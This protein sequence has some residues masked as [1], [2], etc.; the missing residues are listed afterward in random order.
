[1]PEL[2]WAFDL[3][4]SQNLVDQY[5]GP[6]AIEPERFNAMVAR[7]QGTDLV[8][9]VEANKESF[10]ALGED[11]EARSDERRRFDLQGNVAVIPIRGPIQKFASSMS[12][13]TSS[14]GARRALRAAVR[15]PDVASI[16]LVVDSPGGT[17]AGTM[18]LAVEVSKAREKKPVYA[19]L[20]DLTASAAYWVASQAD[21]IIANSPTALVGSIGT[22]A[23]LQ[24]TSEMASKLGVKVHVVRAGDY[25]GA[26]SPGTEITDEHLVETQRIVNS[27][28]DRFLEGVASGRGMD[29][30]RVKTL[31]DGRIHPA[32]EAKSLGLVD[33]I[34][35]FEQTMDELS[36]KGK[37]MSKDTTPAAA[38][39]SDLKAAFP[40]ASSDFILEQ[41]EKNATMT[42]VHSAYS[43]VLEERLQAAEAARKESDEAHAKELEDAQKKSQVTAAGTEALGSKD[44][45]AGDVVSTSGDPVTDFSNL[46]SDYAAKH[47]KDR[48]D[49]VMACARKHPELHR[50]YLLATNSTAKARRQLNEKYELENA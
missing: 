12:D 4:L 39:L 25:K 24:D 27:L 30:A 22:F 34:Q 49:A 41:L 2:N 45:K 14:V 3:D 35:G 32:P 16:M 17:V 44:V 46:V 48:F 15:D 7:F 37:V 19:F 40:N 28:N 5:F 26:G 1:M 9:H 23:V 11:A 21:R 36:S 13:S 6:W 38:T 33:A 20:E 31:A 10:K 50:A 47:G 42:D 18:D 43:R 8:A 29:L